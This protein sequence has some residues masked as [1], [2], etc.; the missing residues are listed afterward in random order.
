MLSNIV[1]DLSEQVKIDRNDLFVS[2]VQKRLDDAFT[3]YY[4]DVSN[5]SNAIFVSLYRKS[6]KTIDKTMKDIDL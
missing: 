3:A 6:M 2:L 4:K 5:S 1:K